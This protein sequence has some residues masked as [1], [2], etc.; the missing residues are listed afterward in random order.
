M[1]V[2]NSLPKRL[3]IIVLIGLGL[4]LGLGYWKSQFIWDD[5]EIFAHV[6]YSSWLQLWFEPV[7]GGRL[8]G[9]YY[10]PIA[11]TLLKLCGAPYWAHLLATLCHVLSAVAIS[12]LLPSSSKRWALLFLVHPLANEILGWASALPDALALCLSLWA[13]VA[14]QR[15][16][17]ILVFGCVLIGGLA[18]E[19]AWVPLLAFGLCAETTAHKQRSGWT[20]G[21]AFA[22]VLGLRIMAGVSGGWA[23]GAKIHLLP[24]ALFWALSTLVWPWPL[25]I[26][27]DIHVLSW[28]V[29]VLGG[30]VFLMLL[31]AL[32]RQ[33]WRSAAIM[34]FLS[35]GLALPT[36]V[37]GGL[38][39]ERYVYMA[40][41][42]LVLMV[43]QFFSSIHRSQQQ[44]LNILLGGLVVSSLG[45]HL[46]RQSDWA[47]DRTL[48]GAAAQAYP[49]ASYAHHFVGV[50]ALHENRPS[51][52]AVAFEKALL[53]DDAHIDD[54]K[55]YLIA[56]V[57]A[58][59]LELAL[60]FAQAGAQSNLDAEYIAYWA[61]AYV[62]TQQN[63]P[64]RQLLQLLCPSDLHCDGPEWVQELYVTA[65]K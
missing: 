3:N 22:L 26:V 42:G 38:L 24:K 21:G 8:G 53:S 9:G 18:K 31:L 63:E 33:E 13:V 50:V 19:T 32:R 59:Q 56:L 39:G 29:L 2:L 40:T 64:A 35:I 60:S 47:S 17:W 54:R 41:A 4:I 6:H 27:H 49:D 36:M 30:I 14:F 48:F 57:E 25:S 55:L 7:T 20:L 37:D 51:D 43:G 5:R 11:M 34:I 58:K 15:E 44:K 23:I 46:N 45:L 1:S 16:R 28:P 52:A 61:R 10:R 62:E 12:Q 65:L